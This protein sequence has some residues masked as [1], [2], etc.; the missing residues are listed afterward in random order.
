M[1]L[2]HPTAPR[3]PPGSGPGLGWE[4]PRERFQPLRDPQGD[5]RGQEGAEHGAGS[6]GTPMSHRPPCL[7]QSD[8]TEPGCLGLSG[9]GPFAPLRGSLCPLPAVP[10][11]PPCPGQGSALALPS[12]PAPLKALQAGIWDFPAQLGPFLPRL[13]T[14]APSIF[15]PQGT[16]WEG[17][18]PVV[19]NPT[20]GERCLC[21]RALSLEAGQGLCSTIN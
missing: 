8:P 10:S 2:L 18:K 3:A 21:P 16:F 7:E 15:L 13:Q 20:P 19:I 12:P 1:S 5:S 9:A 14:P 17:E 11:G 4:R 6:R